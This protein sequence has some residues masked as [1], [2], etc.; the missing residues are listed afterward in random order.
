MQ[1][2]PLIDVVLGLDVHQA[3]VE[4]NLQGFP[5][6]FV[7][8]REECPRDS[9]HQGRIICCARVRSRLHSSQQVSQR[10]Q[11]ARKDG[12]EEQCICISFVCPQQMLAADNV[13]GPCLSFKA[14]MVSV[15]PCAQLLKTGGDLVRK[16]ANDRRIEKRLDLH[17]AGEVEF[18]GLGLGRLVPFLEDLG[19]S[20]PVYVYKLLQFVQ[21]VGKL[22]EPLLEGR[23]FRGSSRN[24]M[25]RLQHFLLV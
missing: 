10:L 3:C 22:L 23:E 12:L 18:L 1:A 4:Q 24:A 2:V 13:V 20:G 16:L 25:S 8:G 21:V 15:G 9:L 19:E 11:V 14:N 17:R 6:R 5:G 7:D